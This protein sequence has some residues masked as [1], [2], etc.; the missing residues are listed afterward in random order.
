M[1]NAS[2][3][4]V[5]MSEKKEQALNPYHWIIVFGRPGCG[6]T[7]SAVEALVRDG[8]FPFVYMS[9]P[10]EERQQWWA[11]VQNI[12]P[13]VTLPRTFPTVIV[14]QPKPTQFGSSDLVEYLKQKDLDPK[15]FSS[16]LL[17]NE[18]AE[19]MRTD[20]RPIA[21]LVKDGVDFVFN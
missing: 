18:A 17:R 11:H 3:P 14:W 15:L 13:T 2:N 7:S 5:D 20:R 10:G 9:M 19:R 12:A 6:F 4:S 16:N 8:R 21:Q 1:A